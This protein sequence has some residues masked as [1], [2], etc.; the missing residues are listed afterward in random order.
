MNRIFYLSSVKVNPRVNLQLL[1]NRVNDGLHILIT[2]SINAWGWSNHEKTAI[3]GNN[4]WYG[5]KSDHLPV[6]KVGGAVH[7]VDDPRRFVGKNTRLA[8][9]DRLFADETVEKRK[10]GNNFLKKKNDRMQIFQ[11]DGQRSDQCVP[12]PNSC[13][14]EPMM[15]FSTRSSVLV[16]RSTVQLLVMTLISLSPAFLISYTG[17][18]VSLMESNN[19]VSFFSSARRTPCSPGVPGV[20]SKSS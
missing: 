7:R 1:M 20:S 2:D 11:V 13:F 10:S 5:N 14:R 6:N 9:S 8:F 17:E 3:D 18:R 15:I 12:S 16:T 19:S 4:G